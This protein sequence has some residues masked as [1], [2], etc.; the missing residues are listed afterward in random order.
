MRLI[1]QVFHALN[2][3]SNQS[4]IE[5]VMQ[6]RV[7]AAAQDL[8]NDS[9]YLNGAKFDFPVYTYKTRR[10]TI[11]SFD[12]QLCK[13]TWTHI[14]DAFTLLETMH[15]S[16]SRSIE[17][18]LKYTRT[19]KTLPP[20]PNSILTSAQ[21]NSGV[22]VRTSMVCVIYRLE[23]MHKVILHELL[24]LWL[25]DVAFD[26]SKDREIEQRLNLRVLNI[27]SS[28]RLGEAY[29]DTFAC[30]YLA[31]MRV[32]RSNQT[33][34]AFQKLF[35]HELNRVKSHI[36][37]VASRIIHFYQGKPWVE[38]T[39]VFS[40]YIAKALIFQ[41]LDKFDQWISKQSNNGQGANYYEFIGPL[42]QH[43]F[44]QILALKPGSSHNTDESPS[45]SVR[46]MPIYKKIDST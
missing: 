13:K 20:Q 43:N 12:R 34:D 29:T 27:N 41:N 25:I 39:H 5:P 31:A 42:C 6:D 18:C 40:Y 35:N 7:S 2:K 15:G 11:Y 33:I 17:I 32:Y 1:D 14:N 44:R 23:E 16:L 28:I 21:V 24:H 45:D 8:L 3:T 9:R 36:F 19:R 22:S 30:L 38:G 10:F 46:M 37:N 26:E 4:I